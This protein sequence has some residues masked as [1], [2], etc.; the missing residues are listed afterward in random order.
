M[1]KRQRFYSVFSKRL[2]VIFA[3]MLFFLAAL[4]VRLFWVQYIKGET[5]S[6]MAL[7]T[8]MHSFTVEAKRGSICDRNGQELAVSIDTESIFADPRRIKKAG[9]QRST[10][11]KLAEILGLPEQ[12]ILNKLNKDVSFV[13]IKRQVDLPTSRKLKDLK[14]EGVYSIKES[15]RFYPLN[16]M[17]CHVLGI[18]GIDNVGL[19]GIDYY[20]N[21]LLAGTPGTVVA[22]TDRLGNLIPESIHYSVPAHNGKTLILTIDQNIQYVVEHEADEIWTKWSPDAVS[23]IV[24]DPRTGEILALTNR[25]NFDPNHFAEYPPS[26]RRNLAVNNA[27]EPG[28]TGKI[29]TA[30]A[31]LEERLVSPGDRFYCPAY[32]T[33]Q[34]HKI[35]EAHG[36]TYGDITFEKMLAES[37]NVGFVQVG[38]K[39]G[40]DRYYRYAHAFGLGSKTGIDLPGEAAG[41]LVPEKHARTIDLATM[42]FGQANAI[43]PIQ[44][45]TA[46][47]AVANNGQMMK[48]H[49]LKEIRDD[50]GHLVKR[51]E[52]QAVRQV[53]SEETSQQLRKMLQ[54]VVDEGTGK[55]AYIAG[56]R[57][58]GKTGTAQKI[59]PGG[60]YLP[61]AYVTSFVAI[62]PVDDPQLVTLVI[63]DN[64]KGPSRFGA[65]TAAPAVKNILE[66]SLPYLGVMKKGVSTSFNSADKNAVTVPDMIGKT[67]GEAREAAARQHL[68]LKLSGQGTYVWDQNPHAYT[69]VKPGDTVEIMLTNEKA[70]NSGVLVPDVRGKSMREAADILKATGLTF[71][72][73]GSGLAAEQD[74]LP[75]TR[76]KAGSQVTIIFK[77]VQ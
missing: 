1:T 50:K 33:V 24:M 21:D 6:A 29:I 9:K 52:P 45:I 72:P 22:E 71:A 40:L 17:A 13:W 36:K 5:L 65:T 48:P 4:A 75:G 37:S 7:K 43:T 28:S 34:G 59:A 35:H 30:A 57:V 53:I 51:I 74:P 12:E 70:E 49:L 27:L 73:K 32:I 44:L 63:V 18:C 56:Y 23:I 54:Y 61:D 10:A 15:R 42:A 25:P 69:M 31:A 77:P 68:K 3:V 26:A 58:G 8:R 14:L 16:K 76:V 2:A 66:Y 19:E 55:N 41:I 39:L 47:S 67:V 20:Y 11:H 64:P 38:L 46:V 60:G 62:A